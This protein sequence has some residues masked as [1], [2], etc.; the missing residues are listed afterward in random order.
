MKTNTVKPNRLCGFNKLNLSLV[1]L[2]VASTFTTHNALSA[3][4][5][6]TEN[7]DDSALNNKGAIYN[8]LD[9]SGVSR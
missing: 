5:L 2:C 3:E 7:F 4:A 8:T 1:A 6:W 9:M